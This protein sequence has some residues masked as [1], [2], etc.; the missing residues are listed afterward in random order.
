MLSGNRFVP[1]V[2]LLVAFSADFAYADVPGARALGR[3]GTG[4]ADSGDVAGT[5]ENLAAVSLLEQYSVAA[6]AGLGPDEAWVVRAEAADSRTSVVSLA[7]GYYRLSDNVPP[8]GDLLPAWVV[9]GEE[10]SNISVHQGVFLGV[11]YPFLNRRLSIGTVGR[12]DWLDSELEG[13]PVS[14]NFGFTAAGKPVDSLTIAAGA[15]DLLD[16]GY[17]DMVRH[18]SLGV[19]WAPGAYLAIEAGSS[20]RIDGT[21][22]SDALDVGGGLDVYAVKWLVVRG[23]YA[24]EAQENVVTGGVGIIAEGKAAVDYGIRWDVG[25]DPIR[26][27]HGLDL[28]INF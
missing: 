24:R 14:G 8:T 11:A 3:A 26:L 18:A 15:F 2:S 17:R 16:L 10:I 22:F 23:G 25:S 27:R 1:L 5:A 20:A 19:R 13:S 6:G 21:A 9:V 7:A 12:V 4:L 28:R